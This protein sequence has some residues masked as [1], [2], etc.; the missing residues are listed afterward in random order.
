MKMHLE[1]NDNC[2]LHW[3]LYKQNLIDTNFFFGINEV[4][5]RLN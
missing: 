4:L 5:Y 3:N 2:K 1:A